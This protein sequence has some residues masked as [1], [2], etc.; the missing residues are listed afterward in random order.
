M[1]FNNLPRYIVFPLLSIL[2]VSYISFM[3]AII[4]FYQADV[5]LATSKEALTSQKYLDALHLAEEALQLN[6]HR[7]YYYRNRAQVLLISQ[8]A[9]SVSTSNEIKEKIL[10]DLEKSRELNPINLATLR[11]NIPSYYYLSLKDPLRLKLDSDKEVEYSEFYLYKAKEYFDFLKNTY[12]NDAG[13][14]VSIA[15]YQ[16]KLGLKSDYEDT[17]LKIEELRS[18]LL[19]WHPLLL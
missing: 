18:D 9:P 2:L 10:E 11:N 17:L 12:P 8:V 15:H 19:K 6:P 3:K 5:K 14:L 13:L 7:P 4:N 1:K 16:K